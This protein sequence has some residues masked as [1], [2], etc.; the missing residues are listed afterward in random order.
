[1]DKFKTR[2]SLTIPTAIYNLL[3]ADSQKYGISKSTI[4][5][6]LLFLYYSKDTCIVDFPDIEI[7]AKK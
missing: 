7:F 1:M 6:G 3:H 4:V 2:T 5:T